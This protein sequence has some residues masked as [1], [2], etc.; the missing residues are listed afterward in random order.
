MRKLA[1][2][3]A[4]GIVSLSGCSHSQSTTP[5]PDRMAQADRNQRGVSPDSAPTHYRVLYRFLGG[6]DG[7]F[8]RAGLVRDD[9]GNLYGTTERG[10]FRSC[11]YGC[12][13]VF[14]VD[15]SGNESV[16]HNFD[17]SDGKRP[18]ASVILDSAGNVYG[19]TFTGGPSLSGVVFKINKIGNETVLHGFNLNGFPHA[20]L[21]RDAAGNLFG[22]AQAGGSRGRGSVFEVDKNGNYS[23]V[24][25]FND[26]D[27]YFPQA[28]VIQDAAGNLYGTTEGG[29]PPGICPGG[30][31]VV[32]KLDSHGN[33][34]VLHTFSKTDG[35]YPEAGLVRDSAGNLYG[36]TRIG[37]STN[38]RDSLGCGVV[39]KL[40]P[41]GNET[42]LFRFKGKSGEHPV[43]GLIRNADG[44]LFG[45]TEGGGSLGFGV[46]FKLDP[47]GNETVLHTFDS[48]DGGPLGGLVTDAAGNLYGTAQYNSYNG[49]VFE[50]TH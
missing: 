30:C 8:P 49:V 48:S 33:E 37:G 50:L 23:D 35:E 6:P 38:C 40:D 36:T 22:T 15:P 29:G 32:F 14:K 1:I 17:S 18:F 27:G 31:G 20:A 10:G 25:T 12:G 43:A 34:T 42:T 26:T 13:V 16:L 3:I 9:A 2:A 47:S 28:N 24:H 41:S 44:D 46:V 4:V 39:F 21:F 11:P 45:T 19:T 5:Q 7:R